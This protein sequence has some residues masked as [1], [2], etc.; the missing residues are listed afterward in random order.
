[1]RFSPAR[2][3]CNMNWQS[4]ADLGLAFPRARGN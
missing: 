3:D 2:R 1:M 4:L